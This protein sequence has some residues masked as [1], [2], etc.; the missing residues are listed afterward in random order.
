[1]GED[2]YLWLRLHAPEDAF[3]EEVIQNARVELAD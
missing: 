2:P 1:M 3:L